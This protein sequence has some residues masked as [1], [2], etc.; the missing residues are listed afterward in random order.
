MLFISVSGDMA[1]RNAA[2]SPTLYPNSSFPRKYVGKTMNAPPIAVLARNI[3][4]VEL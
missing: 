2:I 3:V 1:T 4:I